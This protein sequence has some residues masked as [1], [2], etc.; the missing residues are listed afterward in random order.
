[1][2]TKWPAFDPEFG[3]LGNGDIEKSAEIAQF[4]STR[5]IGVNLT[6]GI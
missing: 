1:V 2:F 5:T 4:P 6:V 3:T